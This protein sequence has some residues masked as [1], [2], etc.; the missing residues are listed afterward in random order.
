MGKSYNYRHMV[1]DTVN[2]TLGENPLTAEGQE[3]Y[4]N[5]H[6]NFGVECGDNYITQYREGLMLLYGI[7]L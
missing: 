1:F 7:K 6:A 4:D 2:V 5:D 3:I